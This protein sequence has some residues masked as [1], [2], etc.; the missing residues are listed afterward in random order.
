MDNQFK[1][2]DNINSP[3]DLK[4][5]SN[6]DLLLSEYAESCSEH[7]ENPAIIKDGGYVTPTNPGY[8]VK[9]KDSSLNEFDY[10][11]GTYWK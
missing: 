5:L 2:L 3:D 4:K 8:S 10:N 6:H 11:N 9:I 7:F 1:I